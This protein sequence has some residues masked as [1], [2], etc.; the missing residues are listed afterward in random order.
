[1]HKNWWEC[2]IKGFSSVQLM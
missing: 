1:L 2:W